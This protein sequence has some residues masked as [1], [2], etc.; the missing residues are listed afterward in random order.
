M[1]G[2]LDG[3]NH[4]ITPN[5]ITF[6]SVRSQSLSK[7]VNFPPQAFT[8]L[9]GFLGATGAFTNPEVR[10]VLF[11][12]EE[13]AA[14]NEEEPRPATVVAVAMVVAIF[15]FLFSSFLLFSSLLCVALGSLRFRLFLSH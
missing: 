14:D 13:R 2:M 11:E 9:S 1:A 3:A 15:C 10:F 5:P 4:P 6:R 8:C 12:E 7:Q